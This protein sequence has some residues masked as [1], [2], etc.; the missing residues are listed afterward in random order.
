MRKYRKSNKGFTL[1]ELVIVVAVLAIL[2]G[3]LAP[4][5]T[6][7][8]K[9]S[10]VTKCEA[11]RAEIERVYQ[12]ACIEDSM[13][14]SCT[15][16]EELAVKIGDPFDY[17][18][19]LGFLKAAEA[20]C[21][22]YNEEYNL[23]LSTSGNHVKPVAV[24]PCIENV[25]SYVEMAEKIW[26]TGDYGQEG[27]W[28]FDHRGIIQ[29]FYEDNGGSLPEV[30][31]LLKSGSKFET[32]TLYWRP[33]VLKDGKVILYAS[34]TKYSDTDNGKSAGWKAAMIYKDGKIY[35]CDDIGAS[36]TKNPGTQIN[37]LYQYYD[38]EFE[39]VITDKGF[40][41]VS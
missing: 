1:I 15:L 32:N 2:V 10:K 14:N 26:G 4:S 39:K 21:P 37:D 30:S 31:Q 27:G 25:Y 13:L 12:I 8:V 18:E 24:C 29:K 40:S 28:N 20:E 9:K 16:T 38:N 36:D 23:R 22:V 6:K 41:L 17:L 35:Q 34:A 5:Y 3:L 33:Y 19:R 11:Q 7:Y